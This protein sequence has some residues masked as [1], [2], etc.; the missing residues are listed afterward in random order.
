LD[1]FTYIGVSKRRH[2]IEYSPSLAIA[3]RVDY[4]PLLVIIIF[5]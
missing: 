1:L 5:C 4:S 3:M 2:V